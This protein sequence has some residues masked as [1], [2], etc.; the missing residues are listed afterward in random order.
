MRTAEISTPGTAIAS[1]LH[2][3]IPDHAVRSAVSQQQLS[4]LYWCRYQTLAALMG[5]RVDEWYYDSCMHYR[6]TYCCILFT[7]YILRSV[8]STCQPGHV[9]LYSY[10]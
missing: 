1:M 2:V 3:A 9:T 8:T 5:K 10:R 4:F 7:P 6:Y